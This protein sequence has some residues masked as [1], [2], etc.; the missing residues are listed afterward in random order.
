LAKPL[1]G[2]RLHVL[3]P[4]V[5]WAMTF[6]VFLPCV[7]QTVIVPRFDWSFVAEDLEAVPDTI[8]SLVFSVLV[9]DNAASLYDLRR[10]LDEQIVEWSPIEA[11]VAA[12]AKSKEGSNTAQEINASVKQESK[13]E[14]NS[15]PKPEIKP[16]VKP[17]LKPEVKGQPARPIRVDTLRHQ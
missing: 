11:A 14:S 17:M 13:P 8:R 5:T 16:M 3:P 10:E 1:P 7:I 4:P 12:K 2:L 6:V 15:G 9:G